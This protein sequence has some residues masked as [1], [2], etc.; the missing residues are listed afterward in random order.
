M[1]FC[2]KTPAHEHNKQ[3]LK[4]IFFI[5]IKIKEQSILREISNR[6]NIVSKSL[7]FISPHPLWH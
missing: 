7:S 6:E 4:I 2:A 1:G 3:M 5:A